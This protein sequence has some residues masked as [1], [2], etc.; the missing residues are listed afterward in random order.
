MK[1][2]KREAP[3]EEGAPLWMATYA[4][5]MSLL[6]CFFVLLFSISIIMERRFQAL[7]DTLTQDFTGHAGSSKTKSTKVRTTTTPA[8]SAAQSKRVAALLGGQPVPGPQGENTEV[9]T[10]LLDGELVKD[11]VICFEPGYDALTREAE[12]DLRRVLPALQGSYQKIMVKGHVTP[13]EGGGMSYKQ[14]TDLAFHRALNVADFLVSLGLRRD[15]FEIVV[16]TVVVPAP[17]LL[18]AGTDPKQAGASV[19]IILLNQTVRSLRDNGVR[20]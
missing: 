2:K 4:D 15:A 8:D 20:P 11:G 10:I 3:P 13:T 16:D 12:Q 14:D 19:E 7:A 18:P 1:R 17:N 6:L 9:H 5:L